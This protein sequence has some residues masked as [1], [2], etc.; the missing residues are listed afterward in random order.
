MS[1][2]V[3][4]V[5]W[6]GR[7]SPGERRYLWLAE[8]EGE[9]GSLLRLDCGRSRREL[10]DHLLDVEPAV[11]GLDFSFS[12]PAWWL[13]ERGLAD[14]PAL[15]EAA[16]NEGEGWLAECPH[17]FWGRGPVLKRPPHS[18]PL[19]ATEV[20][21]GE[22]GRVPRSTFQLGGAGAVGTG[23]VRGWPHLLRL[24]R[25]G[26]GIWPWDGAVNGR[27][28]VVEVWPRLFAPDVVKSSFA[29]RSAH[30]RDPT[31]GLALDGEMEAKA[32]VSDDAFDAAVTASA[33]AGRLGDL[34]ALA[35]STDRLDLI[36]GRIWDPHGR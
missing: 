1:S 32:I 31:V 15:W 29:A 2:R 19:R 35:P 21:V 25:A 20:R 13:E 24:R 5:D 7:A 28:L 22:R 16:E 4:A 12:L 34:L 8:A 6:S 10:V 27:P 3:I 17:P 30:V 18:A 11:V 33:M 36:E 14:G 9:T 23:S 26:W